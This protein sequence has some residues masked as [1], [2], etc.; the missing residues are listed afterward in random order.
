MI[1]LSGDPN[2]EDSLRL[3]SKGLMAR[4]DKDATLREELTR[5]LGGENKVQEIV[6]KGG[7]TVRKVV[8]ELSGTGQQRIE[9]DNS[10]VEDVIQR[11][12][13]K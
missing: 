10:V 6:A 1:A 7:S 3:F 2:D 4:L 9:A 11:V 13:S 8:Q 12:N 5:I